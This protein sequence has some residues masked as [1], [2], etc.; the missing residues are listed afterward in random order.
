MKI[1]IKNGD[2]I[3]EYYD[4]SDV[5]VLP[6]SKLVRTFDDEGSL[7]D[8]FKLLGKKITLEDDLEND[9]TEII[10]TLDVKK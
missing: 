4:P 6:K 3:K 1:I 2:S 5:S 9:E 10:V 8:E 7:I